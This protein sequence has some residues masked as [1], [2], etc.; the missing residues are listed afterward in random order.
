MAKQ[1]G[2]DGFR[3]TKT[4]VPISTQQ[5]GRAHHEPCTVQDA[6]LTELRAELEL[7][8]MENQSLKRELESAH[9]KLLEASAKD[10]KRAARREAHMRKISD[11]TTQLSYSRLKAKRLGRMVTVAK[12]R[13]ARAE[14]ALIKKTRA[15]AVKSTM[16][17]APVKLLGAAHPSDQC[18]G[19][20]PA[21]T[22]GAAPHP[23][24]STRPTPTNIVGLKRRR[25]KKLTPLRL[26]QD[27]KTWASR[28]HTAVAALT[29]AAETVLSVYNLPA[30]EIEIRF[31]HRSDDKTWTQQLPICDDEDRDRER[32]FRQLAANDH[33]TL[34]D[35]DFRSVTR[36][37]GAS[38][39]V[40]RVKAARDTLNNLINRGAR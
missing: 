2:K 34:S 10:L 30:H 22:H 29:P 17:T 20:L 1:F 24:R 37:S 11:L 36:D 26:L 39:P 9:D 14:R 33:A 16:K 38:I 35:R 12:Q 18:P 13:E 19:A 4:H 31:T 8:R 27:N 23:R 32:V 7:L 5:R 25:F 15:N 28:L 3:G 40:A 6:E 21:S